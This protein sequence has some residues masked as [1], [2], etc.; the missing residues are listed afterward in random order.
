MEPLPLRDIH[1]PEPVG[2]WPPA[3]GWW[4]LPVCVLGLIVLL[5]W[6]I[7]R[8]M[9]ITPAKLALRELKSLESK[10]GLGAE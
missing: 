9:R 3:I 1:L 2:W 4:L 8:R 6:L 5:I 10:A 7:R